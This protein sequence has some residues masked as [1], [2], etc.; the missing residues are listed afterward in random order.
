MYDIS[1]LHLVDFL[2]V[3]EPYMD[4]IGVMVMY[5]LLFFLMWK[6]RQEVLGSQ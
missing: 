2:M 6:L 3:N 5:V 1:Y 4:T